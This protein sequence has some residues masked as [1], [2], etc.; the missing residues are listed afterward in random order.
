MLFIIISYL[1]T[2]SNIEISLRRVFHSISRHNIG[3]YVIQIASKPN[4]PQ[5]LYEKCL[6]SKIPSYFLERVYRLVLCKHSEL[7]RGILGTP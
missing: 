4:A 5:I 6:L 7:K 1:Q 2:V 3:E